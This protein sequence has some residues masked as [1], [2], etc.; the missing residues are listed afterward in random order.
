MPFKLGSFDLVVVCAALHHF[1]DIV[2]AL[3]LLK[4]M[5]SPGGKL[6]LM[7]E[8]GNVAPE[9]ATYISELANGFNEQQC[10]LAEYQTMFERA[11]LVVRYHRMD[12][13]C[14]YKV[15]LETASAAQAPGIVGAD[16]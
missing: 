15:I 7:R 6:V 10:V 14:S 9:D 12:F 13:E 3:R 4:A 1:V 2:Q 16:A 8:P 5:L 11:G